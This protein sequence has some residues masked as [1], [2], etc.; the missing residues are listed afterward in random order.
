M[1]T[2]VAL[3][4]EWQRRYH[5]DPCACIPR[6]VSD[7]RRHTGPQASPQANKE[8]HHIDPDQIGGDLPALGVCLGQC[9]RRIR[10]VGY[11]DTDEGIRSRSRA[12]SGTDPRSP[13]PSVRDAGWT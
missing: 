4:S 3:E 9:G 12:P 2:T 1:H 10:A 13:V 7:Q 6:N 5:E 8:A 11:G